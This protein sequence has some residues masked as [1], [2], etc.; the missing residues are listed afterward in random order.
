MSFTNLFSESDFDIHISN[1]QF[2]NLKFMRGGELLRLQHQIKSKMQIYNNVFR[3]ITG[4]TIHI[5]AFNKQLITSTTNV[6]MSNITAENLNEVLE[7]FILMAEGGNLEIR[8]S[9][10]QNIY[11]QKV[12]SVISA[13]Y[14]RAIVDAYN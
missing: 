13:G 14:R 8:D 2:Y 5:E 11:S 10:F 12:G 6:L 4:G 3:N 9:K 7:S 1:S